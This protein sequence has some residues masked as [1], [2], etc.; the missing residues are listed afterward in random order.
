MT[1]ESSSHVGISFGRDN[2]HYVSAFAPPHL[3]LQFISCCRGSI[4]SRFLLLT[5]I[6]S[7]G[8]AKFSYYLINF[9]HYSNI[10]RSDIT[11]RFYGGTFFFAS[12]FA[13]IS[14]SSQPLAPSEL[15]ENGACGAWGELY[16]FPTSPRQSS[17][18][19][20]FAYLNSDSET[21]PATTRI[22]LTVPSFTLEDDLPLD[23][24][25][26]ADQQLR[27][28]SVFAAR[29]GREVG[30]PLYQTEGSS[31][32]RD[33]LGENPVP[34]DDLSR[35]V[36]GLCKD[37]GGAASSINMWKEVVSVDSREG[38]GIDPT[39]FLVK[40]GALDSRL[41]WVAQHETSEDERSRDREAEF[42]VPSRIKGKWRAEVEPDYEFLGRDAIAARIST[43]SKPAIA[44]VCATSSCST[45]YL[46]AC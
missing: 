15:F 3:P 5:L 4:P 13:S 33:P 20:A 34:Q 32:Y 8:H 21:D 39:T 25:E 40:G 29:V 10:Y 6:S 43:V 2:E 14:N 35:D 31:G 46:M 19:S 12:R 27:A 1:I 16:R 45:G 11:T 36:A 41:E 24:V 23:P 7:A 22:R 44:V 9:Q 18:P 26:R 38:R 28:L 42:R 30:L 37:G 17:S